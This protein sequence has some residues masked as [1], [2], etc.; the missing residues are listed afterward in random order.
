MSQLWIQLLEYARWTPSPHNLQPWK[1]KILSE[2]ESELYY[3][4]KRL[5]PI[6]D[7]TGRFCILGLGMFVDSLRIA[8][9]SK[10]Y[11]LEVEY[12]KQPFD[13]NSKVPVLFAKLY[14]KP[15][16]HN[17]IL[18]PEIIKNRRT[19]RLPYNNKP[20]SEDL[21]SLFKNETSKFGNS[22]FAS[23][24]QEMVDWIVKLNRDT[25]FY[26]LGDKNSRTEIGALLRFS[27]SEANSKKDGLWS[28]CF[29]IPGWFMKVFFNYEKF[30]ELPLI[31]QLLLAYYENTMRGTRTVAWI[32]APF[33][34]FDDFINAG[35]AFNRVWLKMAENDV[36]LHP[37]GSVITNPNAHEKL[38]EKFSIDESKEM[39]WILLRI[40]YSEIPPRSLR[41]DIEDILL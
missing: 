12:E 20:I 35:Y 17:E 8:A 34:N 3:D 39:V 26:D 21:I 36:Y 33:I 6:T 32:Q 30:F 11:D 24:D 23:S 38:K 41:L 10:K 25:L 15:S 7:P 18:N 2:T 13:Y 5:L 27:N 19:S 9:S 1:L 4:S 40:G 37:F 31:K 22:F 28:Y 16:N 14:L 29:H